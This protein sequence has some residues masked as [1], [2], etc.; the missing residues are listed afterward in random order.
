L[1]QIAVWPAKTYDQRDRIMAFF[2]PVGT[3]LLLPTWLILVGFGYVLMYWSTGIQTL[4]DDIVISG[5]S[6]LTLGFAQGSSLT[7]ARLAFRSS[8]TSTRP[9]R[10]SPAGGSTTTGCCWRWP[11]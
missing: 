3:L 7:H 6:L 4:A 9:G 1:F 2:A 10:T 11:I 8:L 5:S